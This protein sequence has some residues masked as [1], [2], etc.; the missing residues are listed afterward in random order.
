MHKHLPRLSHVWAPKPI[1]FIT[2]AKFHRQPILSN[3]QNAQILVDEWTHASDRHGW[4]IGRYVIMPDHVHFFCA[5]NNE[6]VKSISE[7]MQQWK[8]WTSKRIIRHSKKTTAEIRAPVW[9]KEF[10]DHICRS[11]E[12]YLQKWQYVYENPVRKN[13]VGKAEDWPWQGEVNDLR[14]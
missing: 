4:V 6:Y 12:S 1:Y 5:T 2:T 9:Q 3:A 10:F 11:E 13:L 14:V 8:Q 7:F